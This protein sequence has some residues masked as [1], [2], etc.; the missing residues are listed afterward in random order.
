MAAGRTAPSH[1]DLEQVR[2]RLAQQQHLL[3]KL[4]IIRALHVVSYNMRRETN[5]FA[6]EYYFAIGDI[7]E[8]VKPEELNLRVIN[9]EEFL[10]ELNN[11]SG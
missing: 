7:L 10:R 3:D 9:K 1:S 8:G 11:G 5:D 2:R 6:V 4:K